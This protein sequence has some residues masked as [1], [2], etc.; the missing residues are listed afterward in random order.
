MDKIRGERAPRRAFVAGIGA[1]LGAAGLSLG[2]LSPGEAK[3][4]ARKKQ[5][6]KCKKRCKKNAKSCHQSC[7]LLPSGDRDTCKQECDIA[8]KACT[9]IC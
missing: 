6:K 3:Q 1:V 2:F 9:R 8:K 7:D 5:R 4:R